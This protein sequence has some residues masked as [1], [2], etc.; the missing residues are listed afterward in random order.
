MTPLLAALVFMVIVLAAIVKLADQGRQR[1]AEILADRMRSPR[2]QALLD[3]ITLVVTENKHVVGHHH[4]RAVEARGQQREED[5]RRWMRNGCDA[6]EGLAPDFL[7]ALRDVR[8]LARAVSLIVALPPVSVVSYRAWEL[9]GTAG[10]GHVA[11][12]LLITGRQQ[13]LLRLAVIRSAFRLA[14]ISLRAAVGLLPRRPDASWSRIDALVK[15]LDACG[16]QGVETARRVLSA[17]DSDEAQRLIRT[18]SD[19]RE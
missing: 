7:S 9:R 13:T 5:A 12:H 1:E 19:P 8:R 14:L 17:L 2:A 10:L 16:D 15:D 3:E 4:A 6:I 18:R 11:H